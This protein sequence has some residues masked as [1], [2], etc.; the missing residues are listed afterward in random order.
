MRRVE[1]HRPLDAASKQRGDHLNCT[2]QDVGKRD[3]RILRAPKQF[4][5][6]GITPMSEQLSALYTTSSRQ[7]ATSAIASMAIVGLGGLALVFGLAPG[8]VISAARGTL[9]TLEASPQPS[10]TPRPSTPAPLKPKLQADQAQ[11]SRKKDE[12]SPANLRNKATAVFAPVLPPL[13]QP[14]PIIAAPR[15]DAG[16]ASNTGASD[17]V[18]P[19]QGAGGTGDG[20]GGGGN[21]DGNGT[22]DA[23]AVTR[24]IQ[25]KGKLRWSDLP[26]DLR[27]SHRGGELE[28]VYRVNID[29]TVSNCRVTTS[30]GLPSLDAQTCRLITER[31]RF[32]PSR[33]ASGRAVPGYIIE[34]HGWDPVPADISDVGDD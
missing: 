25:I 5:D 31:F 15:P 2:A 4:L 29:G 27:Q 12:A 19:G 6:D 8:P 34:R 17:R 16:S 33:D 23:E 9:V 3:D 18:G 10:P 7:R 32:R 11:T 20:T 30:S 14:A 24:P 26:R 1:V 21:G 28:L 22:G 13:R